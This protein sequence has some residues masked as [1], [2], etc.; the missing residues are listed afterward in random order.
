MGLDKLS[1]SNSAK[2]VDNQASMII[3][4]CETS[5]FVEG[6]ILTSFF[7]WPCALGAGILQSPSKNTAIYE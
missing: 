4:L 2:N 7:P 6:G 3:K 5:L 1:L